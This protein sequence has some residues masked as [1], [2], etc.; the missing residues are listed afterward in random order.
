M[1]WR[2]RATRGPD[3]WAKI[4]RLSAKVCQLFIEG[5]LKGH[6]GARILK[7]HTGLNLIKLF[8]AYLGV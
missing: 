1:D 4:G 3:F 5:R 8:G 2:V 6:V 7:S